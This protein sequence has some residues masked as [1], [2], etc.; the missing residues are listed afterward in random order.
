MTLTLIQQSTAYRKNLHERS[1]L[2]M[3]CQQLCHV[4][5]TNN[6]HKNKT[7]NSIKTCP[8]T[9]TNQSINRMTPKKRRSLIK[10]LN[11][12]YCSSVR[13]Y[14]PKPQRFAMPKTSHTSLY[15][16]CFLSE[17][18][19]LLQG[20][21]YGG[22]I[23]QTCLLWEEDVWFRSGYKRRRWKE[24]RWEERRGEGRWRG[25]LWKVLFCCRNEGFLLCLLPCLLLLM[26]QLYHPNFIFFIFFIKTQIN[27]SFLLF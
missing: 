24:M 4:L 21:N 17:G 5:T 20:R 16:V 13:Y 26:W 7:K 6:N 12:F 19:G 9:N 11:F 25:W 23:T 27:N 22:Y 10:I 1:K 14:F 3:L 18:K 8:K 2:L 15:L